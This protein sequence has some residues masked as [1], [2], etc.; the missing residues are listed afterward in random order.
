[1][2]LA[3]LFA[4]FS[5]VAAEIVTVGSTNYT[6]TFLFNLNGPFRKDV[7]I[8]QLAHLYSSNLLYYAFQPELNDPEYYKI[9][10]HRLDNIGINGVLMRT[11]DQKKNFRTIAIDQEHDWV[12]FGGSNGIY[13]NDQTNYETVYFCCKNNNNDFIR[14][15]NHQHLLFYVQDGENVIVEIVYQQLENG[16]FNE[17]FLRYPQYKNVKNFVIGRHKNIHSILEHHRFICK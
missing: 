16:K 6:K 3:I 11:T 9:G 10:Y 5:F 14:L 17:T 15:F 7:V 8:T 4:C 2:L 12:F 13:N 1:M